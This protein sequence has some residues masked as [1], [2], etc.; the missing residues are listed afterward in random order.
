MDRTDTTAKRNILREELIIPF[1]H[2]R[3][4]NLLSWARVLLLLIGVNLLTIPPGVWAEEVTVVPT[5]ERITITSDPGNGSIYKKGETI[6]V[7]VNWTLPVKITGTPTLTLVIGTT[8]KTASYNRG[9]A[10]NDLFFTYTVAEGDNDTDGISVKANSLSGTITDFAGKNAA[11]LTH[12]A[13]DGGSTQQVEAI[14]PTVSSVAFTSTGP[15][16][17]GSIIKVKVTM[18]ETVTV[19]GTP[20]ITLVVGSADKTASYNT[21]T[22]SKELVFQY[23][24]A[25]GDGDDT[26]GVSVKVN[27]LALNSGTIKDSTG[28]PATLTHT[29]QDG[30]TTHK[31]DTI[32]PTVSSLAFT[33]TGPYKIGS[34]I[35]VTAIMSEA[36]NVTGT[37]QI[38][39]VV[40][41][42][43][44]TA[45]YVSGTGSNVL[46]FHYTVVAGDTDTDGA[47]VKVNSLTL[48]GGTIKD[49][50][51]NPATLTHTA[52]DGGS[53]HTVDT[54]IPTVS[55][56]AFTS[57]GPYVTGNTIQVTV[58]MSENVNVTGTPTLT[59]EIGG[60]VHLGTASYT[61][62]SGTTALVFQHTVIQGSNDHDGVSVKANSLALSG[63]TIKDAGGNAA[64]LTH[65]AE[66]GGTSH[67]VDTF[68]PRL[69]QFG[70]SV[71]STGPYG[72][73]D[74]IEFS[75][76]FSEAVKVTG[77]PVLSGIQVG[78]TKTYADY[79]RGSGTSALVFRFTVREGINAQN[80][81][82]VANYEVRNGVNG[83][84]VRDLVGNGLL[85]KSS[86]ANILSTHRV[87]GTK[88]TV[89]GRVAFTSTGPYK[90]GDNIDVTVTMSEI[91]NVTDTPTLTLVI[92]ST[93][94][95]A[96]YTSGTGT[97]ALVFRYTVADGDGDDT[98]GVSVKANT[99]ALN[100]GTIKDTVGN[101][102]TLTH[103][104]I[105]NDTD[106]RVDTTA[107][108]VS[109][110][111]FNT[112]G[113]YGIGEE[114]EIA[115]TMSESVNVGVSNGTPNLT[116][117]IGSAEKQ[118]AYID[119]STT[120]VLL[121]QYTVLAS[122]ADDTDGVS[123]KANS[124]NPNGGTIKDTIG[125]PATLTHIAMD[126]GTTQQ[127]DTTPPIVSS[128]AFTSTG[129]YKIGDTIQVTATMNE[130]VN[131]TGTPTLTLVIGS[132][133][134]TAN[135][136]SG[137]GTN[138]L[139]FQ[140]TV[141]LADQDD[142]DGVSVKANSLNPN[143]GG[144]RDAA[145]NAASLTHTGL[146]AGGTTQKV[147][148]TPP[149]VSSVAF[150]SVGSLRCRERD[151]GDGDNE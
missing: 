47:S 35:Q 63:G 58:T 62:G 141:V 70:V 104:G 33:N 64:T 148:A 57:T 97:S 139:V 25:N 12:P 112:T 102:A 116:L 61:S 26:D 65:S 100:G 106:H 49:S 72:I 114:I 43:D 75:V 7:Q 131:I 22:G 93:N 122:D 127:V 73:G 125:N 74:H 23:T 8:E 129:P 56:I 68:S 76:S 16:K 4:G 135:Y 126:G 149:T 143:T 67:L 84:T 32:A 142:T 79:N 111:D 11:T 138:A 45:T 38:T 121:F 140:Y 82:S 133:D 60:S 53:S 89:N 40:G 136:T 5:V 120:Q 98:D 85:I 99:L 124:L 94:K 117:L 34:V 66:N 123:V 132:T 37:P 10:S 69:N 101:P 145:P 92:G 39:L 3:Q 83:G 91:V 95:T 86:I 128:L 137:T 18:S 55:S 21:G 113:P 2:Q 44:K 42:T 130:T 119:G 77:N 88:P 13:K 110:V 51:G 52:V 28:N 115:V 15:Y 71:V 14:S 87:D 78:V 17:A 146:G 31:V 1:T 80:G 151:S 108:T 90:P 134:R 48:N 50:G 19:T 96:S 109:S 118:A 24:V 144:I 30:G 103:I 147:D 36:V 54:T 27:S 20:Q 59:L 46:V 41:T 9:T 81:V 29:A 6:T 105:T 107:P 150:T